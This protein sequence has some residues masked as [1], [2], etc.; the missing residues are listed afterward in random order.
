[1]N[2]KLIYEAGILA[3]YGLLVLNILTG[4]SCLLWY[5][6]WSKNSTEGN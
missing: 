2:Q 1:M 5:A 6:V 3:L 4:V